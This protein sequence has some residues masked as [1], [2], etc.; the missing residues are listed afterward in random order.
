MTKIVGTDDNEALM[1]GMIAEAKGTIEKQRVLKP[2]DVVHDGNDAETPYPMVVGSIE[3]PELIPIFDRV[4]GEMSWCDENNVRANLRKRHTDGPNKGAL[5]FTLT[6][7]DNPP[8]RG[9]VKCRLHPEDPERDEWDRFGFPVCMKATLI[10]EYQADRHMQRKHKSEYKAIEDRRLI[11]NEKDYK[12]ERKM[13]L[14]TQ[15]ALIEA[16]LSNN[17]SVGGKAP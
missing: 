16:V 17:T 15:R 11:Q 3:R 13:L 7:P 8:S 12:E 9:T 5:V 14:D 6:A 10:N 2:G 1:E 4:S